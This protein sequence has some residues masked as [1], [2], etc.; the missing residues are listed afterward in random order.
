M[1]QA[2]IIMGHASIH[3]KLTSGFLK[4]EAKIKC[5]LYNLIAF[6]HIRPKEAINYSE[7]AH[8]AE[9]LTNSTKNKGQPLSSSAG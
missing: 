4:M 9:V 7:A 3:L 1:A 6:L 8:Y 2:H 5:M